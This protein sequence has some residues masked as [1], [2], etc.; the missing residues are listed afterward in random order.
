MKRRSCWSRAA[1]A[2]GGLPG[3][4][5]ERPALALRLDQLLDP[6]G[7]ERADQLV[8]Q[9]R[10]ADEVRRGRSPGPG[11]AG[12]RAPPPG[13]TGRPAGRRTRPGRTGPRSARC[14]SRR[15]SGPR[16]R[17]RRAGHGPDRSARVCTAAWSLIPST[18]TTAQEPGSLRARAAAAA[19]AALP[20]PAASV[21]AA[22]DSSSTSSSLAAMQRSTDR[23]YTTHVGSLARPSALLDLPSHG[24]RL[25]QCGPLVGCVG[26]RCGRESELASLWH[27][28][29]QAI[30]REYPIHVVL[31]AWLGH[32]RRMNGEGA[33]GGVYQRSQ[34]HARNAPAPSMGK[35]PCWLAHAGTSR[36]PRAE[37]RSLQWRLGLEGLVVLG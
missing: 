20:A 6:A 36:Q 25:W 19:S 35:D 34:K 31:C 1:L 4:G 27:R 29:H 33:R 32:P 9:V 18:S 22:S 30:R 21:T 7:A 3:E 8:L 15:P 26:P 28:P 5:L 2:V 12:N 10:D 14:W 11:R 16:R 13:R 23:I 37:R 24:S 17:L